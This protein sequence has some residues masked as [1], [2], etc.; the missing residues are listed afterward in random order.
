M[1]ALDKG[2]GLA[3]VYLI[4]HAKSGATYKNKY[5][6]DRTSEDILIMGSSRGVHH[7]D[8]RIIQ[9][10]LRLS[11]YNCS[12][13]GCGSI[14]ALGLLQVMK[15]RHLPKIIIYDVY[16]RFD[17]L[18]IGDDYSKY[19]GS[20]KYFYDRKGVDSLF[21]IACPSERWKMKSWI[22]RLNQTSLQIV[23][24]NIT[25][26]RGG[27]FCGYAPKSGKM[28]Q[29]VNVNEYTTNDIDP[30]KAKCFNGIIQLCKENN[31]TLI[32]CA[33]PCYKRSS[34]H[35]FEY[36]R[37]IAISN[38]I[39]FYSHFCDQDYSFN[40]D[41]FYDSVHMNEDGATLFTKRIIKEIRPQL[42]F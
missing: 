20:L 39:P 3:A 19:L 37:K 41:Y 26:D 9:D 29:D 8:P 12:Y 28:K 15:E 1:I 10:S 5:I 17:Y 36:V 42:Q 22:Y 30:I 6:C 40:I 27:Y 35:E 2:I 23:A 18:D 31:V 13:E 11:C 4:D 7:Y 14:T 16:P 32:L 21:Q 34:D 24:D 33:S 25:A 38:D